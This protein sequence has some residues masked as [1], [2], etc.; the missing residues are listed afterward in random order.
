MEVM[1]EGT[2]LGSE[3]ELARLHALVMRVF[4]V[5]L[6]RSGLDL[7]EGH[8]TAS[9]TFQSLKSRET[10]TNVLELRNRKEEGAMVSAQDDD[11]NQRDHAPARPCRP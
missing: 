5:E 11:T 7:S 2:D 4:P 10:R 6:I 9:A 8:H 3:D 1:D